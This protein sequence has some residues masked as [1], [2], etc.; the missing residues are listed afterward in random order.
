MQTRHS[1]PLKIFFEN[2]KRKFDWKDSA[3]KQRI[4]KMINK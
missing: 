3:I 1:I 2:D 4:N